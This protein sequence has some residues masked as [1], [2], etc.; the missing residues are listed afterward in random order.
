[1]MLAVLVGVGLTWLYVL[2]RVERARKDTRWRLEL[3]SPTGDELGALAVVIPARDEAHNIA[4]CVGAAR[5]SEHPGLDVVVFDDASADDTAAR[6]EA[7]GAR[8]IRGKG[9]PPPGWKGKPWALERALAEIEAPW[10]CF[11]DADVRLH[12]GA[13]AR[14]HAYAARED[15]DLLSGY[16]TLAMESWGEKLLQP[17]VVALVI[18][19]N[20]LARA[21]DPEYPERA[22]AN[23]QLLFVR[24]ASFVERGGWSLVKGEIVDDIQLARRLV[25]RWARVRMLWMR[26]LFSCRMYRG[27][28]ETWRG[29]AKNLYAGIGGR[30]AAALGLWT[31]LATDFVYPYAGVAVGIARGDLAVAGTA[32]AVIGLMHGVRFRLDRTFGQD[33]RWGIT[34]PI[35][36]LLVMGLLADSVA[37]TYLRAREWKGR[38]Y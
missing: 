9:Q 2:V 24:R 8:V 38:R 12:P 21:N 25:E 35:G 10:V 19:G 4:A 26:S 11:V 32:V 23:G 13:L 27:F 22:M 28:G 29:W 37:R 16:G 15:L 18:A 17:A 7:A 36:A 34:L 20:D 31:L 5:A 30:P 6:A 33:A 1:M 3:S 14:I